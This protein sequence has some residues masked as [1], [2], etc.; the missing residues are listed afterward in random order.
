MARVLLRPT[1]ALRPCL[2]TARFFASPARGAAARDAAPEAR[3]IYRGGAYMRRPWYILAGSCFILAGYAARSRSIN[4][5]FFI[6]DYLCWPLFA[7]DPEHP[8]ELA[9]PG[10]RYSAAVGTLLISSLCGWY[11]WYSPSRMITRVTLYPRMGLV[12]L[13]TAAPSPALWLPRALRTR[14]FF[15]RAGIVSESDPFE[16]LVRLSDVY[17]LQGSAVGSEVAACHRLVQDGVELPAARQS[18]LHRTAPSVPKIDL[19]DGLMLRG[20]ARLAF[21][22]SAQ[23]LRASVLDEPGARGPRRWWQVLF[24]GPTDW[25]HAPAY[26]ASPAEAEAQ[27]ARAARGL[28]TEPWFLD[29]ANF[30][31]LFPLDATRYPKK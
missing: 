20:D 17:R 28:D 31:R 25:A 16:R 26:A 21:Q 4:F 15:Q 22:L 27:A 29:R 2:G 18:W 10:L 6:R 3:V 7:S 11:F 13:R 8:P 12:G 23:P 5:A 24:K 19:Q 9:Q 1:A 14:P 30:D